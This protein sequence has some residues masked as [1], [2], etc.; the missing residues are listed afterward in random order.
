MED[1]N[2]VQRNSTTGD[3][4]Q[5]PN[6]IPITV[7]VLVLVLETATLTFNLG[8]PFPIICTPRDMMEE[9]NDEPSE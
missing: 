2:P 5:S 3:E 7:L 9:I 4:K 1:T 8:L 6:L